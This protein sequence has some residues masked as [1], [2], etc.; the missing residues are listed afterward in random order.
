MLLENCVEGKTSS[1]LAHI[2]KSI[3]LIAEYNDF[4]DIIFIWIACITTVDFYIDISLNSAVNSSSHKF[5][6]FTGDVN[7]HKT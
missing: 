5:T 3:I 7:Q 4:P 1:F 6:D 2:V